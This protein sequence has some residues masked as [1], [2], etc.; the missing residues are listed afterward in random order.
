MTHFTLTTDAGTFGGP[1]ELAV[2][3]K[4]LADFDA[5]R[6]EDN[7]IV[8][9]AEPPINGSLYLQSALMSDPGEPKRYVVETR[10]ANEDGS[11]RHY[12]WESDSLS[13]VQALFADYY[14]RQELPDL[15][16]WKDI[17]DIFE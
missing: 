7:F 17:T 16:D 12:Q 10:I 13:Q 15:T 2:L 3:W 8:L 4:A 9:E 11:F 14:L 1:V 5:E 6:Y